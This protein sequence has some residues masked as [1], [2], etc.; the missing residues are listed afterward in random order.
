MVKAPEKL[1]SF[2]GKL[3][4]WSRRLQGDNLAN[5]P[6]L[7]EIFV[8]GGASLKRN[9][10]LE[11][12]THI[13]SLSASFENCF[14][15]GELN[16]M[17]SYIIDPFKFNVDKLSDDESYKEDLINLKET[18]NMKIEFEPMVL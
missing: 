15:S 16:V 8:E 7:H 4:L 13:E 6:F 12:V 2:I 10:Q 9:V 11:I 18:R 17:E 1:K 5:F 14:S 3:F